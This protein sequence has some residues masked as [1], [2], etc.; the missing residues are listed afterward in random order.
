MQVCPEDQWAESSDYQQK[1]IMWCAT[2]TPAME[3]W[4][5]LCSKGREAPPPQLWCLWWSECIMKVSV[6][7]GHSLLSTDGSSETFS[8]PRR[9]HGQVSNVIWESATLPLSNIL[10]QGLLGSTLGRN[11]Q[12]L[13]GPRRMPEN[14]QSRT[15]EGSDQKA[16]PNRARSSNMVPGPYPESAWLGHCKGK[17]VAVMSPALSLRGQWEHQ[18]K[19]HAEPTRGRTTFPDLRDCAR[20]LSVHG[21]SLGHKD[22]LALS[23]RYVM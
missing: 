22:S 20:G 8:L 2:L 14:S 21:L 10:N 6:D 11:S 13:I 19:K 4:S 15:K 1:S 18:D 5:L 9:Q 17:L 23:I 16:N 12:L 7:K 3:E